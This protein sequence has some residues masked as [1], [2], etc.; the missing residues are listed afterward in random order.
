MPPRLV[1]HDVPVKIAVAQHA[2]SAAASGTQ[3]AKR[4]LSFPAGA[5]IEV[6]EEREAGGWWAVRSLVPGRPSRGA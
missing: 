6:V 2:W 3:D 4:Y 5:R 1:T